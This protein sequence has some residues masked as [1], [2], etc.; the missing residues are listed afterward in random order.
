MKKR[1]QL[2]YGW[3]ML[4]F[5]ILSAFIYVGLCSNTV[6]L[7]VQPVSDANGF[8]RGAFT[9]K[10]SLASVIIGISSLLY[11]KITAR[12]RL[13][14]VLTVGAA[15]IIVCYVLQIFARSLPMFYLSAIFQG[16]GLGLCSST[17]LTLMLNRWFSA[18][19]GLL[20]GL[21]YTA[22]SVG[23]AIFFPLI[24]RMISSSSYAR[25]FVFS[26]ILVAVYLV[27]LLA[28]FVELPQE[29]GLMP[30]YADTKSGNS[31][32][33]EDEPGLSFDEIRRSPLFIPSIL[34]IFLITI[35]ATAVQGT[36]TARL[37]DVGFSL[38]FA[39]SIVS[40]L[41]I[42]TSIAKVPAGLL[43][44]KCGML[45][46]TVVSGIAAI[47]ALIFLI[48]VDTPL[49]AYLMTPF[50]GVTMVLCVVPAPLIG[51]SLYGRRAIGQY[52]G[53]YI[54]AMSLGTAVGQ[55]LFNFMYDASGSYVSSYI[56]CICLIIVSLIGL[57]VVMKKNGRNWL[58]E[59][60][61]GKK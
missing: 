19:F 41:Y 54:G 21:V 46:V 36:M 1:K 26:A 40:I 6:S 13:K 56:V 29:K 53:I 38:A 22:T 34:L 50:M 59:I 12:F 28:V 55:T 14:D 27:I 39:T 43:A 31:G 15:C 11:G 45:P 58:L 42:F 57:T 35:A 18:H 49:L 51:P 7:Y 30:I 60:E 44:D 5:C 47:I 16:V 33:V 2:H 9:V 25:G 10:N 52:S 61:A 32:R 48:V 20:T 24:G 37:V 23:G 17:A 8:P 3:I 4:A